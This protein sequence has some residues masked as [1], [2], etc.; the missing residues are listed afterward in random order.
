MKPEKNQLPKVVTREQWLKERKELLIKEKELTAQRDKLNTERRSLP[1]VKIDKDYE[2]AGTKGRRSLMDLFEGRRQLI[3][4]HF[5]FDPD[6]E[7]GCPSCSFVTDNIGHLSHLHARD[8]NLVLVSRA[9]L[10]KLETY[11][12]RM[13]WEIPWFSSFGSD[14][15]YDFH[16]TIDPEKGS[17][18]YNYKN[19]RDRGNSWDGWKGEMPGVSTFLRND[20]SVFHTYSSYER[21]LDLLLNTYNYLDLSA[22]GRQEDW[23]KPSGRSDAKM[24]E[25]VRRHDKYKLNKYQINL[26]P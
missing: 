25:W 3:I 17:D 21:G 14:F 12:K 15:N 26:K 7:E 22:L 20:E 5:M 10:A 23:E 13:G 6:W 16:V 2:F 9:P 1:M 11:K 4:Y 19:V 8:T 18:E 24:M